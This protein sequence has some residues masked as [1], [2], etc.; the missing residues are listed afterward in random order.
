MI[1]ITYPAYQAKIKQEPGREM[2]FDEVRKLWVL[3]TPEEWVRQNFLQY[4]IQVKKYPA[5]LIAVEKEIYLGDVKKRFDIVVYDKNTQPWMLVECKEMKV[6]LNNMVLS[7][8]LR[9]NIN[10]QV[11]YLVIT[12]G[13]YG[14]AFTLLNQQLEEI[15]VL[16]EF[17]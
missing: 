9:Y 12:N 1:K 10:L 7:Q 2:I 13:V 15:D 11:P 17:L 6:E 4:L 16:P 8:A 5:A 14:Y 3:L